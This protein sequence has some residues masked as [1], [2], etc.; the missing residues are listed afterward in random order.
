[1]NTLD[2]NLVL[3]A[4]LDDWIDTTDIWGGGGRLKIIADKTHSDA[5]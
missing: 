2:G 1:M 5:T 4:G 3:C